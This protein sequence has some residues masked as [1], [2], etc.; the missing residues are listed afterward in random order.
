MTEAE[1]TT[2]NPTSPPAGREIPWALIIS[3]AS[4]GLS[5]FLVGAQE[6]TTALVHHRLGYSAYLLRGEVLES[7]KVVVNNS[8]LARNAYLAL[9][10]LGTASLFLSNSLALRIVFIGLVVVEVVAWSVVP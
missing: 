8:A 5:V 6:R 10:V 9:A 1:P 7:L 3:A 4:Q 2:T